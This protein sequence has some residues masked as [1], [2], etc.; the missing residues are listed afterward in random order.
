MTYA[1]AGYLP[2]TS[3]N[4]SGLVALMI[5]PAIKYTLLGKTVQVAKKGIVKEGGKYLTVV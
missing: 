1:P 3:R 2:P 4:G 5:L